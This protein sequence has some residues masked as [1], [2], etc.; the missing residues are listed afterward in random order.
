[1]RDIEQSVH[2]PDDAEFFNRRE[3]LRK[4]LRFATGAGF[5]ATI[6]AVVSAYYQTTQNREALVKTYTMPNK[7]DLTYATRIIGENNIHQ[8]FP[9][10]IVRWAEERLSEKKSLEEEFTHRFPDGFVP[11]WWKTGKYIS[12][13]GLAT[14][15]MSFVT[16]NVVE[17]RTN[18][19][20]RR[21]DLFRR[22]TS[23]KEE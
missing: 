10:R 17:S 1:M 15:V 18:K 9:E 14:A 4:G 13:G 11:A 12:I 7:E 2:H 16:E 19:E 23:K 20:L 6:G 8:D 22:A 5:A 3:T 21:R